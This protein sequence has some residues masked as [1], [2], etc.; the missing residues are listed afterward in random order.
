MSDSFVGFSEPEVNDN[1]GSEKG[2]C[3]DAAEAPGELGTP[4]FRAGCLCC[5]WRALA[6]AFSC[7]R[8][9]CASRSS[10]LG[11]DVGERYLS[12]R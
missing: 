2:D 8:T 6:R 12:G 1:D 10:G 5:S 11:L 3:G 9:N 7:V 4:S